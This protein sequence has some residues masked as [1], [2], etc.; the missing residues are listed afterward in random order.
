MQAINEILGVH[1]VYFVRYVEVETP[2]GSLAPSQMS[3]L[4]SVEHPDARA[5]FVHKDPNDCERYVDDG[6]NICD[7]DSD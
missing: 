5:I 1:D 4:C 6:I 2:E 7:L 3:V